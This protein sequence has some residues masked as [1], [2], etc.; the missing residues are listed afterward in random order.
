MIVVDTNIIAYLYI[1]GERSVDAEALLHY[2]SEWYVPV[3]WRSEFNSVL[4]RYRRN[5]MLSLYD[6]LEIMQRAESLLADYEY[7]VSSAE[8]LALADMS[9]CST[10]DCEFVALSQRLRLPLI[11]EDKK[12]HREFPETALSIQAYM[13]AE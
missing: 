7:P 11:T 13:T 6:V 4:N 2:D 1:A 8:V 3:L 9:Q 12:I 5:D 10:Y